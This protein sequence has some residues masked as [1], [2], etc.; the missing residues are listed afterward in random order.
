MTK[1][2]FIEELFK[3]L[4]DY[5][6][7]D[8]DTDDAWIGVLSFDVKI[9]FNDDDTFN[10]Y[11]EFCYPVND[12]EE[13][14]ENSFRSVLEE[15]T[16][17]ILEKQFNDKPVT[18]F[19]CGYGCPFDTTLVGYWNKA[20][21]IEF[22]TSFI[23]KCKEIEAID[24]EDEVAKLIM[25]AISK[26]AYELK[27]HPKDDDTLINGQYRIIVFAKD[28][29]RLRFDN[30]KVDLVDSFSQTISTTH[31]ICGKTTSGI[32]VAADIKA[33][34]TFFVL[35]DSFNIDK[36]D[37][38]FYCIDN[39]YMYIKGVLSALV[40][41]CPDPD[42][43]VDNEYALFVRKLDA[44]KQIK[45]SVSGISLDF[46]QLTDAQFER[47]CYDLLEMR[48]FTNIHQVGKTNSPDGGKDIIADEEY[49]TMVGTETRKWL[50]QCK[51]SKK[52]LNRKDISEIGDLL[53][54]NNAQAYGLF[55]SNSI[56]PDAIN[57]LELKKDGKCKIAY[58]GIT[59][60]TTMLTK[61][62]DLLAKYKLVGGGTV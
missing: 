46:S 2:E 61:Y 15:K 58:Y 18:E 53:Q 57:R 27:F 6:Y 45:P 7:Y 10:I 52:S 59:E 16:I 26:K 3:S 21:N 41:L 8:A 24:C 44:L 62:P 30:I 25:E 56:T 32:I 1:Q 54:E 20:Y 60:L 5:E 55:C 28:L 35:C 33:I 49:K 13:N 51:H 22:A 23:E 42:T 34:N 36:S 17:T 4:D 19:E 12:C 40:A 9:T 43:I 11:R 29:N 39:E 14:F 37:L 50:W 48:G 47:L 38:D 31:Y